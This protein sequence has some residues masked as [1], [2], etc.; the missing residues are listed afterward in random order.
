MEGWEAKRGVVQGGL[1]GGENKDVGGT[2][3]DDD[4]PDSC[5]GDY[6]SLL[7]TVRQ[8]LSTSSRGLARACCDAMRHGHGLEM[9]M[10]MRCDAM[11]CDADVTDQFD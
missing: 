2:Q 9:R 4:L 1:V 10:R 3:T 5:L 7:D 8:S 6:C 11:R